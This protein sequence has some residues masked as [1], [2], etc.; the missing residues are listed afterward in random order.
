MDALS[1]CPSSALRMSFEKVK[2]RKWKLGFLSTADAAQQAVHGARLV[3]RSGRPTLEAGKAV[4]FDFSTPYVQGQ[5]ESMDIWPCERYQWTFAHYL[6]LVA[7]PCLHWISRVLAGQ[8]DCPW[9]DGLQ[10]CL[11]SLQGDFVGVEDNEQDVQAF[12][13]LGPS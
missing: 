8:P 3:P 5:L 2:A 10:R 1:D 13:T 6:R 4:K 12:A 11:D 7:S 9:S